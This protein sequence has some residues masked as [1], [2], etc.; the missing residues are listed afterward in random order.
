MAEADAEAGVSVK[1]NPDAEKLDMA[2]ATVSGEDAARAF[3]R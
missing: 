2:I 1:C 3:N